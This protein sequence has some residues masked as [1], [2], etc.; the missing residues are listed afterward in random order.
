MIQ[1]LLPA[2]ALTSLAL[3]AALV[4]W[5]DRAARRRNSVALLLVASY[6]TGLAITVEASRI[7][8]TRLAALFL[9]FSLV[10]GVGLGMLARKGETRS[11]AVAA[12]AIFFLASILLAITREARQSCASTVMWFG[13]C[14]PE[15]IIG[16]ALPLAGA[17]VLVRELAKSGY[18]ASS[19]GLVGATALYALLAL[20]QAAALEWPSLIR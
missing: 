10:V 16:V 11:A 12:T 15:L 1:F 6:V 13:E 9:V 19:R 7:G 8:G 2:I 17:V 3:L 4:A 14:G 5:R 20:G 18:A